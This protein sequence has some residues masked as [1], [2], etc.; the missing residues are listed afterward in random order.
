MP[1]ITHPHIFFEAY[2]KQNVV[3]HN[4]HRPNAAIALEYRGRRICLVMDT[5]KDY[6]VFFT[7]QSR[8]PRCSR[9]MAA[10]GRCMFCSA[11]ICF[12]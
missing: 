3:E 6:K 1:I 2:T 12:V 10:L 4:M 9:A 5:K 11:T 7:R 8:L